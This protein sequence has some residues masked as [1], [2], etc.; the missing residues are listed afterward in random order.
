MSYIIIT[1]DQVVYKS[2]D[3]SDIEKEQCD[4]GLLTVI[5][6]ETMLE[7]YLG[8]WEEIEEWKRHE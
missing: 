2:N 6:V 3:V 1:E 8:H 5:N 4:D 7:Y